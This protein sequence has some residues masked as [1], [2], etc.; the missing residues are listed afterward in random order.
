MKG[1]TF[2]NENAARLSVLMLCFSRTLDKPSRI[3]KEEAREEQ[4]CKATAYIFFGR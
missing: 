4:M 2:G 1:G 3:K